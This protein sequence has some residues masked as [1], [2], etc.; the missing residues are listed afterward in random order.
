M[1]SFA[2]PPFLCLPHP[3]PH[4]EA[5]ARSAMVVLPKDSVTDAIRAFVPYEAG[6]RLHQQNEVTHV[7]PHQTVHTI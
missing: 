1:R 3:F 5:L 7:H 6:H 2:H 4:F